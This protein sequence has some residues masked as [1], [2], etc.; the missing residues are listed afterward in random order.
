MINRKRIVRLILYKNVLKKLY[1]S[2]ETRI[3]SNVIADLTAEKP[4]QVRKDFSLLKITGNRK[5]GYDI[6]EL[7]NNIN[8][9]LKKQQKNEAIIIGS[10]K[11]ANALLAYPDF[12][13]ENIEIVAV[14]D[15]DTAKIDPEKP[16]PILSMDRLEPFIKERGVRVAVLT[17][18]ASAAQQVFDRLV[19][20]GI[21]AVLNFAPV[22]LKNEGTVILKYVNLE[23]ELESLFYFVNSD[24]SKRD[25]E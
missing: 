8:T 10:G 15:T 11:I 2:G 20:A 3:F 16:V 23:V 5:S 1:K 7:I 18:P 17:V 9:I 25:S 19:T 4:T 24:R 6:T 13:E 21:G 22:T 14:F 12:K